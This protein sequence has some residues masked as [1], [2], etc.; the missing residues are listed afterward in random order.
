MCYNRKV[1]WKSEGLEVIYLEKIK[2][3]CLPFAG[4]S[5][6]NYMSWKKY[7]DDRIELKPIELSGRGK[8]FNEPLYSGAEDAVNDIYNRISGEFDGTPYAVFGHSMG[9]LLA[10]ELISKIIEQIGQEPVHVF[11][12]GR[13]PPF[14]EEN[15]RSVHTYPD[16]ELI[17]EINELGGTNKEVLENPEL[18]NLFLPVI[19]SDYKL[20][21]TYKHDRDILK[22]NCDISVL[23][24]KQDNYVKEQDARRWQEC[25]NKGFSFYEFD[26]GHFFINTYKEDV[27]DLIN[28]TLLG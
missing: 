10:Y 7:L 13:F 26:D 25:T 14:L 18:V 17:D 21:E 27:I 1:F 6:M 9:T 4:G 3:F 22:L 15:K 28:K 11:F 8:R 12:S 24:G 5:A 2:L 20:V 19:R 16:K 23:N